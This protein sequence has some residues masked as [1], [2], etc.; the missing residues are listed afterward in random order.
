MK[1]SQR[2]IHL[3]KGGKWELFSPTLLVELEVVM[4][5]YGSPLHSLKSTMRR[6]EAH[7]RSLARLPLPGLTKG[8][9]HLCE[10]SAEI[11]PMSLQGCNI[12][13]QI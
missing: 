11:L 5:K 4:L 6:K 9:R 8:V 13:L 3:C 1:K 2:P 12:F 7:T 10:W